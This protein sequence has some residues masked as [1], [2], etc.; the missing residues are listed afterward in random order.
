MFSSTSISKC[1][2]K[3]PQISSQVANLC[4]DSSLYNELKQN[5]TLKI[6]HIA[7]DSFTGGAESVFRNT[8]KITSNDFIIFSA[9]C[10]KEIKD[11]KKHI[12]LDNYK[13]Y[14]KITGI[15]KYIFNIKN[16]FTL[17]HS[18]KTLKPDII[19]TQNY[20]SLLSPSVLFALKIYKKQYPHTKLI[21]TQHTFGACGNSCFYNY[22][23]KQV[24]KSC[25]KSTKLQIAIKNCDRRGRIYSIIKAIRT[26]FYQGIFLKE[27][28]LFDKIIFVSNFQMQKHIEDNYDKSK[29]KVITNPID[30]SFFN[31]S[32]KKE[33]IIIFFGRVSK[34]KNVSLLIEAFYEIHK[35]FSD[36]RLLIVGD[37]DDKKKCENLAK[38]LFKNNNICIFIS[39]LDS[40]KLKERLRSAKISILPSIWYE[41]FGLT[42]IESILSNI[43]PIASDIGALSETIEHF[44]GYKFEVNNKNSLK[45]TIKKVLENYDEYCLNLKKWQEKILR[46]MNE[47]KYLENLKEIYEN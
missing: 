13:N 27:Q 37:G 6:L 28:N 47:K 5:Q 25:I 23:K 15:F 14:N 18:L 30:S 35:D 21:Y 7:S 1:R 26:M 9:S 19:H 41:S 24:C 42:I 3:I 8:I 34:E 11:S 16:Y 39:H 46:E 43:I 10:D 32:V 2:A 12:I 38:K 17:L 4:E 45:Q 20:L 29:L 33:N 22:H 40:K 31:P 44:G 36:Y